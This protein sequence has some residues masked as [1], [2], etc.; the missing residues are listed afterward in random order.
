MEATTF[1]ELLDG[2]FAVAENRELG[3]IPD[4]LV[5]A[6]NT[7]PL[8]SARRATLYGDSRL[9]AAKV[10]SNERKK[11]VVRLAVDGSR[12]ELGKPD[13]TIRLRQKTDARA[14]FDLHLNDGGLQLRHLKP[15]TRKKLLRGEHGRIGA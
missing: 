3:H 14:W 9:A 4:G 5:T 6:F 10:L 12:L 15:W 8:R 1:M 7:N 13:P 2:C 11:L